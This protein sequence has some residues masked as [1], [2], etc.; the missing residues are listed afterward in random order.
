MVSLTMILPIIF[1]ISKWA[2]GKEHQGGET[3]HTKSHSGCEKCW[4]C[5]PIRSS[6]NG[7]SKPQR[8]ISVEEDE[9]TMD[10]V[11]VERGLFVFV[12]VFAT[13][14]FVCLPQAKSTSTMQECVF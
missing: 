10:H 1:R 8:W 12:C 5:E 14:H 6:R 4:L 2:A 13:F 7:M 3:S 11:V 9:L